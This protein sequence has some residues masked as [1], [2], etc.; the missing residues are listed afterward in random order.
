MKR[1]VSQQGER[2][3]ATHGPTHCSAPER[4]TH[5]TNIT[6]ELDRGHGGSPRDG[7]RHGRGG[8]MSNPPVRRMLVTM[9]TALQHIGNVAGSDSHSLGTAD[10]ASGGTASVWREIAALR[11]DLSLRATRTEV[12]ESLQ[13]KADRSSV[14]RLRM[15]GESARGQYAAQYAQEHK[16]DVHLKRHDMLIQTEI[17][18]LCTNQESFG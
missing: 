4:P 18:T 9:A 15:E 12:H 14:Q 7:V 11:A 16:R 17:D 2:L 3:A 8:P 10:N 6:Y 5:S 13:M 1:K